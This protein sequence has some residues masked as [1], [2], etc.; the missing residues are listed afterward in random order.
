MMFMYVAADHLPF[1]WNH[2]P[3]PILQES[4]EKFQKEDV[5]CFWYNGYDFFNGI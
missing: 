1:V 5:S 2:E 4:W 3:F